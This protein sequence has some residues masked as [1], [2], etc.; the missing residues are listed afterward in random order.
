M[1]KMLSSHY[2]AMFEIF[3]LY[4]AQLSAKIEENRIENYKME[5][6]KNYIC[7]GVLNINRFYGYNLKDTKMCKETPRAR[8]W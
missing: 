8:G 6:L 7:K 4:F 3:S 5:H 2:F 1:E